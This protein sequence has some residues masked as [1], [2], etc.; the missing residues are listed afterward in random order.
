LTHLPK[1]VLARY[2]KEMLFTGKFSSAE[3]CL[4]W[5]LVNRL[6]SDDQR[7][8][9]GIEFANIVTGKSPLGMRNMRFVCNRGLHM[10]FEDSILLEMT[11]THHYCINS[12]DSREGLEALTAK[13]KP[14]FAG[15]GLRSGLPERLSYV[16]LTTQ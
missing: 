7:L 8:S 2:A 1:R 6:V 10:R 16:E 9:A 13:R 14:E 11:A 5:G 15:K 3:D 12:H 4:K